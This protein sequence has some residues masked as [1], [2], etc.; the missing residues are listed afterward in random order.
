M[1]Q[2]LSGSLALSHLSPWC[3]LVS[4]SSK[5]R[6]GAPGS[7]I[8][9]NAPRRT[10]HVPAA[11]PVLHP[12]PDASRHQALFLLAHTQGNIQSNTEYGAIINPG[13]CLLLSSNHAR[14]FGGF[15]SLTTSFSLLHERR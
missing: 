9:A 6:G 8:S 15:A 7:L 3:C 10:P 13:T 2:R 5:P 1:K 12:P 4:P 11:P 14:A